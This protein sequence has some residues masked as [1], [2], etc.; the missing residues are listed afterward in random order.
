MPF[1]RYSTVMTAK[2]YE[3]I[4]S[5]FPTSEGGRNGPL[6][7]PPSYWRPILI[8]N[9]SDEGHVIEIADFNPDDASPGKSFSARL[10]FAVY[11]PTKFP[12]VAYLY[13]GR[14]VGTVFI[15]K[16]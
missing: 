11:A 1:N 8:E 4:V 10:Q 13:E 9:G 14:I 3:A 15:A 5:L 7:Q 12:L 16:G 2:I 6:P